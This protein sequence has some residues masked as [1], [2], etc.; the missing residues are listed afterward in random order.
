MPITVTMPQM[1]ES[2]VEG[3]IETWSV[4]EGEWIEKDQTLCEMTT[5]KVDAEIPAP[6]SGVVTRLLV[7]E[8]ETVDVGADL[9]IIDPAA[10]ATVAPSAPARAASAEPVSPSKP[11]PAAAE[12]AAKASP[13][14]RR[15]AQE[16]GV[17]LEGVSGSGTAGR[18]TKADVVDHLSSS[19]RAPA[20]AAPPQAAAKAAAPAKPGSLG[21]LLGRMRVPRYAPQ[22][23]D[24]IIPFSSIRR[25]IA[26]HMIVSKIVSPHVGTLAEVDMHAIVQFR[27][28]VKTR[29]REANGYSLTYLPFIVQATVRAL[30][31]IPRINST[32]VD[33]NIVERAGI[34]VGVAV[35]TERGLVVP[36]VRN[37]DHYSLTGLADQIETLARRARDRKLTADDLAGG[38]FTISN[39]GR[40]GNL[41]GFAVI[42]QP[43]VGIL[44]MGEIVKRPIVVQHDGE[45]QIAIR[46]MMYLA[47]SYDH[48][49]IDGVTGNGFLY[50]VARNL[51]EGDFEV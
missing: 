14:A 50:R 19:S 13:L 29:F 2:V 38:T 31:E 28:R 41:Y 46:P 32:V 30:K 4:R 39:P 34:H 18:I 6:A 5:D 44:R 23:E 43:Q 24:R 33:E 7:A 51:E 26:E 8:G 20:R 10:E 40:E 49:I 48:R 42:N 27:D 16:E 9:A 22:P 15:I 17:S 11:A 1:G 35:E 21:D 25:R 12:P 45:D 37:T 3:T 47:L 36:V